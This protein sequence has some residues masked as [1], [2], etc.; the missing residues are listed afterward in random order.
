MGPGHGWVFGMDGAWMG[1]GY[2]WPPGA[3]RMEGP[4]AGMGPEHVWTSMGPG[5]GWAL[6][7]SALIGSGHY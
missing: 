4:W 5:D 3:L 6:G 2:G 1:P 7:L